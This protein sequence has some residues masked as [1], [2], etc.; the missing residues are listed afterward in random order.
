M[1]KTEIKTISKAP[2]KASIDPVQQSL[3]LH[4]EQRE[5]LRDMQRRLDTTNKEIIRACIDRNMLDVFTLNI[6]RLKR[7]Y[8]YK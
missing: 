4:T 5:L 2:R 8:G 6:S 3:N 7:C 1:I